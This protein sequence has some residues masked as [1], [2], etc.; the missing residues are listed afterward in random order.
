MSLNV[1]TD[2][3]LLID[4]ENAFKFIN[5]SVIYLPHHSTYKINCYATP[6]MLFNAGGDEILSSEGTT[7][8]DSTAMRGDIL[9]ILPLIKLLLQFIDSNQMNAK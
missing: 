4:A 9:G 5:Y 8:G 1:D 3:V 2:A 6:S 7:Q